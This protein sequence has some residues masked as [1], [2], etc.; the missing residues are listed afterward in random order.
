[1]Q[2]FSIDVTGTGFTVLDRLYEDDFHSGEA[3]GGS[4]GNVLLTLALLDRTV[5]PVLTLGK[6]NVGDKLVDE[7]K[8]AGADTR[9]IRRD[10]NLASPVLAQNLDTLRGQHSFSFFCPE[11]REPFPVYQPISRDDVDEAVEALDSCSVF[12]TD[13]INDAI[14]DAMKRSREAG[15]LVFF[16]PSEII[17]DELFIEAVTYTSILKFSSDRINESEFIYQGSPG[18]ISIV[19]HGSD[20]LCVK[21]NDG[22]CEWFDSV[23]AK[24]VKDTCG[25]GDMVSI[26]IIDW[27]LH[28]D[29][30]S[31]SIDEI[32][33]GVR[34]GQRLAAANCSFAGA[35]GLFKYHSAEF[36]RNIMRSEEYNYMSQMDLFDEVTIQ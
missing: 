26:G 6:D 15:A 16:E 7:F 8:S 31:R 23:E 14:L 34:A 3:L 29:D 22:F 20:G 18:M 30:A 27:L 36:A 4:C 11:T 13:R 33:H 32:G 12:Y 21:D 24:F 10:W 19:T 25:S 17:K 9:Y 28:S 1:M 35:R 5:A 2:Q